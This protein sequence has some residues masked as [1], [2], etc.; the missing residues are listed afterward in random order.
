M[1]DA[2]EPGSEQGYL[3]DNREREA[4]QRFDS[5]GALFDP[6]TFRHLAE[7]GVSD[8]WRCWEVGAGGT[9]VVRR[10]AELVGS[11]GRV[12]ATDLDPRW[13]ESASGV[14]IEVRRHDVAADDPP[15]GPF[16]LVHARLVLI[17]VPGREEALRRMVSTLRPGGWLLVEDFDPT[18]QPFAC[19]DGYGPEQ[20]LANKVRKGFRVLL[21]ERGADLELG[22]RLPRLLRDAGLVDVEADAYTPLAMTASRRLERAN[23]NQVRDGLVA[24][25]HATVEEIERHLASLDDGTLDIAMSPLVSARGRRP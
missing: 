18:M 19:P 13:A 10:L 5:L 23:V 1:T 24:G 22:R 16:D 12:L 25:G 4:E 8:G 17:H 15:D 11:S 2:P 14:N 21:A 6:V 3:L 20:E 7:L 9:S